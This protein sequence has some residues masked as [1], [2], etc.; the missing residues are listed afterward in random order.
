M[1]SRFQTI[2]LAIFL[3]FILAGVAAF[4]TYKA[5][6]TNSIAEITVWGTLSSE[7]FELVLKAVNDTRETPLVVNYVEKS[8]DT[9]KNQFVDSLARGEAPDAV[10]LPSNL[11]FNQEDK[12]LLLPYEAYPIRNFRDAFISESELFLRS[13]GILALPFSVDPMVMYWNRDIFA[14]EGVSMYPKTWEALVELAP[15]ITKKDDKGNIRRSLVAIGEARNVLHSRELLS[16][17]FLQGGETITALRDDGITSTLGRQGDT[18]ARVLDFYTSFSNPINEKYSWNRSLPLSRNY[19][20]AGDLAIYFGFA[21]EI[22]TIKQRNPNLNF[23]IAPMPQPK[24]VKNKAVYATINAFAIPKIARDPN[25]AFAVMSELT[26]P[27]A[28]DALSKLT[29][30]PPVRRELLGTPSTDAYMAI[31]HNAALISKNWIDPDSEKSRAIFEEMIES[32][33]S[34]RKQPTNAILEANN[35]IIEYVEQ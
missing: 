3:L 13:G 24:D 12:F 9:F 34:G 15:K 31:F 33:V 32:V 11:I 8:A 7:T 16:T 19:F 23:D 20:A 14:N 35:A 26:G 1:M 22:E 29:Y 25:S 28:E 2:V 6:T 4:A 10:L 17:L 27:I 21:S 30:L 18:A 5:K